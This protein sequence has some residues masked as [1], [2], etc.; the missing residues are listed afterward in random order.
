MLIQWS[1]YSRGVFST[2]SAILLRNR[3]FG[4]DKLVHARTGF[5]A[6]PVHHDSDK[7]GP[8]MPI[9]VIEGTGGACGIPAIFCDACGQQIA[10]VDQGNFH[11]R[12]HDEKA[13]GTLY[14]SHKGSCCSTVDDREET[15]NCLDLSDL[16]LALTVN[17]GFDLNKARAKQHISPSFN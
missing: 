8:R 10:H 11:W 5:A 3:E 17:L 7:K 15:E 1:G 14:F 4:D 9:K 12:S 13:G 6:D 2:G 16:L